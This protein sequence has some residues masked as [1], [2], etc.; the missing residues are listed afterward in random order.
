MRRFAFVL[1]LLAV[2]L[3]AAAQGPTVFIDGNGS[4][5]EAARETKQVKRHDQTIELA[6]YLLK[7]CPEISITRREDPVPDYF[8]LLNRG[9]EYGFFRSAVSQVMLLDSDKNVLFA[10]DQ[11]TVA[12]AARDGCRAIL[13]DWKSRRA[14][15]SPKSDPAAMWNKEKD[16]EKR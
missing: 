7:S 13:S 14:H 12:H 16:K 11:G 10:N 3:C 2:S 6:R 8:L 4:E 5:M 1:S 15:T 9:E